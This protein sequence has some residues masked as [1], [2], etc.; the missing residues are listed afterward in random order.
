MRKRSH[1]SERRSTLQP[2]SPHSDVKLE[3]NALS[4]TATSRSKSTV[5]VRPMHLEIHASEPVALMGESGAG[6]TSLLNA[7]SGRSAVSGVIAGEMWING[8]RVTPAQMRHVSNFVP[9]DDVVIACFTPRQALG[10]TARLHGLDAA[11]TEKRVDGILDE[12]HLTEVAGTKIGTIGH[13]LSGGQR[14]R[15]SIGT[16][17]VQGPS[18]LFLDEPTSGLDSLTSHDVTDLLLH[19]AKNA[20]IL[21]IATLHQPARDVFLSFGQLILLARGG[22]LVYDGCPSTAAAY[23]KMET[24]IDHGPYHNPADTCIEAIVHTP[25]RDWTAEWRK[26]Y[27]AYHMR[28]K[29]GGGGRDPAG[30]ALDSSDHHTASMFRPRVVALLLRRNVHELWLT[31]GGGCA[32]R[33]TQAFVVGAAEG[34]VFYNLDNSQ[35]EYRLKL[36]VLFAA[37]VFCTNVTTSNTVLVVPSQKV[38]IARETCNLSYSVVESYV[39]H[40]LS[41]GVLQSLYTICFTVP[42]LLLLGPE[43]EYKYFFAIFLALSLVGSVHGFLVGTVARSFPHAQLMLVTTTIP[44]LLFSGFLIQESAVSPPLLPFWYSSYYRYA[45]QGVVSN[46]FRGRTFDH[47]S[48]AQFRKFKCPF[49][50]GSVETSAVLRALDM[51]HER[52]ADNVNV[53]LLFLTAMVAA[54]LTLMHATFDGANKMVPPAPG[55]CDEMPVVVP[56]DAAA[57]AAGPRAAPDD[58]AAD[59]PS[60]PPPPGRTQI[61]FSIATA[62]P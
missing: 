52:T 41:L 58:A 49:G 27:G 34:C 30:G 26:N 38:V 37:I 3:V 29:T 1:H 21:V 15:V 10:Y 31:P 50:I 35:A 14:K 2:R 54:G 16:D 62:G 40:V 42:F 43:G 36:A 51:Q 7:L 8:A 20:N 45:F 19:L 47:C 9:Q 44:M 33:A 12:L 23:L 32:Q 46:E 56:D 24:G 60:P 28:H 53:L 25:E 11:E 4:V 22:Q 48:E 59:P 39:A 5:L 61:R 18:I 17:L 6:K 57:V 13:G 55:A